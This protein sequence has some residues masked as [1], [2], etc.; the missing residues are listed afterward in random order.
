MSLTSII[1][2]NYNGYRMLAKCI[3]SIKRYTKPPYEIIVVDNGSSDR[4][5]ELCRREKVKCLTLPTNQGFPVACNVGLREATGDNLL[6]LNNDTVV[7]PGWLSNMLHC[8]HSSQK[9]GIVGPM[10]NYASGR[11][12]IRGGIA[13]TQTAVRRFNRPNPAKWREVP[14]I[15][16][17]CFLF[18]RELLTKVGFMDEIFSPGHYEDDDYCYRA[19]LAGYR[20]MIAGDTYIYHAGSKSFKRKKRIELQQLLHTN[21]QKF[22]DKWSVDP[23]I[24]I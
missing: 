4:S 23:N 19:R 16:G 20:L 11:Q 18:K 1:I 2:P 6:L 9:I 15:V 13:L 12:R 5:F 17:L 24:F 8:L 10:T 7:K 14:R 21:K 22:I 3:A